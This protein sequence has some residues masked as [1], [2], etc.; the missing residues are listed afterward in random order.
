MAQN[1]LG[2]V[3]AVATQVRAVGGGQAIAADDCYTAEH[4]HRRTASNT[5]KRVCE[6]E[7]KHSPECNRC[8]ESSSGWPPSGLDGRPSHNGDHGHRFNRTMQSTLFPSLTFTQ[9]HTTRFPSS[10]GSVDMG[11]E[12][13]SAATVAAFRFKCC[14]HKYTRYLNPGSLQMHYFTE[15]TAAKMLRG[16]DAGTF[17]FLPQS[18]PVHRPS[19]ADA[20]HDTYHRATATNPNATHA[21]T[22][23][24]P[25]AWTEPATAGDL[26]LDTNEVKLSVNEE[27]EA[28][29]TMRVVSFSVL[30]FHTRVV[31][32]HER[33]SPDAGDA[34]HIF[35]FKHQAHTGQP[36]H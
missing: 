33:T 10:T 3:R 20:T 15:E 7:A 4:T 9:Q 34:L 19:A 14:D 8:D 16:D 23:P 25:P 24:T 11:L 1:S 26:K 30:V 31:K 5:S 18:Q 29:R 2:A 13:A 12:C 36:S 17:V 28:T 22:P 32:L 27:D 6:D 35:C 21:P